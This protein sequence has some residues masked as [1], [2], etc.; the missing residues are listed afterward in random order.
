MPIFEVEAN[1]RQFE[2]EAP[3]MQAASAALTQHLGGPQAAAP[4]PAGENSLAGAAKALGSGLIEGAGDLVAFP[5]ELASLATRGVDAVAGTNLHERVG[6]TLTDYAGSEAIQG[7]REKLT[8]PLYEPQ[9]A[10]EK[11]IKTGGSWA[12]AMVG[13]AGSLATKFGTRVAL[14]VL[15]GEGA[16]QAAEGTALEPYAPVIGGLAGAVAGGKIAGSLARPKA[17]AAV[18]TEAELAA[19]KSAG[20]KSKVVEDVQIDSTKAGEFVDRIV[21]SMKRD[22][23]S[24]KSG[25]GHQE[26]GSVYKALE[27]LRTPEFGKAHTMADFDNTRKILN[28]IAGKDGA[29]RAAANKA[30]DWIDTYT[31]HLPKSHVIA[32]DAKAASMELFKAR[33]DAA[34]LFRS[35]RVTD[36]IERAV[37]NAAST[38]SGGNL[39]NEIQKQLR[40]ILN[41]K[42]Q[43]RGMSQAEIAAI[44]DA[45]HGSMGSNL[46][47]RVGKLLGGGGGLGQLGAT[48]AGAALAGPVGMFGLPALGMAANRLGSSMTMNK[49]NK[50]AELM[51]ARSKEYGPANLEQ[52]LARLNHSSRPQITDNALRALLL[53]TTSSQHPVNY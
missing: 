28:E 38:H 27:E 24:A 20:Y 52:Y 36:A 50:A 32:G 13:G 46:A 53:S 10:A 29:Q 11:I 21:S 3:D 1:G 17:A 6:K 16:R 39:Q 4:A 8:G 18:P 22:R 31:Q 14:P 33:G 2:I 15:A 23:F 7:Y 45:A 26:A 25:G 9:T 5:A 19:V 41:D 49:A 48:S 47:R 43:T 40:N 42:K 30:I 12:P 34:A 35:K 51:R 37:N 44:R